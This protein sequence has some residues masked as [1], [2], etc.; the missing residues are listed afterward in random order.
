[1][2][3]ALLAAVGL[4]V[5]A[6]SLIPLGDA[7]GKVLTGGYGAA[8]GF[9]AFARF[10]V[11]AA[12]VLALL[13]GRVHWPL[14]RDGRVWLRAAL[15]AAGIA[16]ILSALRTEPLGTVFGAFFVGPLVSFAL[17][18]RFL[19]ERAG[20]AQI[21]CLIAGFAGVLLIVRPGLDASPGLLFALAAGVFY[22]AFLAA[23]RWIGGIAPPRQLM[24]S[25][26]LLGTAM[27]APLGLAGLHTLPPMDGPVAGLL[28]V[29]GIAS[30]SGN[31]LL[32]LAY[33]RAAATVLAPFVYTQLA[34]ATALGWLVFGEV[35]DRITA[36]GMAVIVVAGLG[37]LLARRGG[38]RRAPGGA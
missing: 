19:G 20:R 33:R 23:S 11:G 32:I 38:V 31:L 17:S 34:S 36:I 16:C 2:D 30:A 29:S 35:P 12:M 24:L 28:L 15:I 37:T 5:A 25:Q 4:M 9:V 1:M 14:Y 21:A 7:A 3:R 18:V 27:L 6:M 10:G 8:P 13:G 22:G 26:T